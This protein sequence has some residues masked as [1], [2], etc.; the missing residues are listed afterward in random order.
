M[1]RWSDGKISA[2]A[3]FQ[4]SITPAVLVFLRDT[5]TILNLSLRSLFP[6]S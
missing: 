1:E 4:Y 2:V 3:R 6:T 5:E